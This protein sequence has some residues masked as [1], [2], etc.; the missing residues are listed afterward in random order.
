ME[1][2]SLE[3]AKLGR[4]TPPSLQGQVAFITG[5]G[6]AIGEGVARVLRGAG[7]E[8]VLVDDDEDRVEAVRE[9]IGEDDCETVLAD[10]G[11]ERQMARAFRE[12]AGY[13]GGVDIVV[14][15]AGV[16]EAGAL[17]ELE[18][19]AFDRAERVNVRGT[20][21]ATHW[22]AR[23]DSIQPWQGEGAR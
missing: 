13:F 2:W 22:I 8:L 14:H 18:P 17:D 1:Y 11:D 15:T 23:C 5:G 9:R 7:A 21:L 12:A 19:E 20:F 10:V 6:G 3:Q 4:K 16:A